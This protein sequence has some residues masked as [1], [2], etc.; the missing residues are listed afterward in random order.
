ML[1]LQL[2]GGQTEAN[3][4]L[5]LLWKGIWPNHWPEYIEIVVVV[6]LHFVEG[7]MSAM[8]L[9]HT[10]SSPFNINPIGQGCT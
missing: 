7:D 10:H 5:L 9:S 4:Y 3:P 6:I 2:P 1:A 8:K